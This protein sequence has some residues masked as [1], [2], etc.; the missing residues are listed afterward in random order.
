M[1]LGRYYVG[2]PLVAELQSFNNFEKRPWL[3]RSIAVLTAFNGR[4]QKV[5]HSRFI[6]QFWWVL[7]FVGDP[8]LT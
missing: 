6:E 8:V 5:A 3:R 7:F 4:D 1:K 2:L